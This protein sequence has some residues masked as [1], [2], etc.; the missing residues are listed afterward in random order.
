MQQNPKKTDRILK[1]FETVTASFPYPGEVQ[2]ERELLELT[3]KKS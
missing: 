1:L 3:K 2:A